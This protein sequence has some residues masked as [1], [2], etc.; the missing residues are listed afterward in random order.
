VVEFGR[1][2]D[3]RGV[4]QNLDAERSVLGALL[5]HADTVH[6]VNYLKPE[7]FYL[8]RHQMIY[9]SILETFDRGAQT[10]PISVEEDLNRKG[11][12][13]EAGGRESLLDLVESVVSAAAVA[14]H[15]EIVRDR[16]IQRQLLETCLDISRLAYENSGEA[17]ELLDDAERRIFE[18]ARLGK[19]ASAISITDILHQTF[20][21]IDRLREAEGRLTGLA[22]GFID[23]DDI[24]AGLQD[25]ELIIIAARPSM[26]KTSLA[27]N[28]SERVASSGKPVVLFS[29]EM[30]SQQVIQ[31]MLCCRAQID[32]QALRRGRITDQQYRRLQEQA[33]SLYEADMFVDDTPGLTISGLRAR[34]RRLK[35]KENISLVVLDYLQLMSGGSKVESRQQEIAN[36]S[37]GLKGLARELDIPVVALSQLNREVE[38]RDNHRPRMSDLRESGAIEQDADVIMLLHREEYYNPSEENAGLAQIIVAKQRNGPTGDVTLR[39][40]REYMRFENFQRRSEPI[41]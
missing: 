40:F 17:R 23:L 37:R 9:R 14:Y 30:S 19:Q 8:P 12:L 16:A 25:G 28:F 34:C 26:G 39:F 3:G 24:T 22:T 2:F 5:L 21:R 6:E 15:A 41:T 7:D 20:E 10:D 35:Q 29:L 31:N 33:E 18:I 38:S 32:S 11:Q 1:A 36:I 13:A 4:P 27:I